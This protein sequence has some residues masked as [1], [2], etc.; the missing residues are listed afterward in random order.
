MVS[1]STINLHIGP[2]R[3]QAKDH[4]Q[5]IVR[6]LDSRPKVQVVPNV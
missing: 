5:I 2:L 3:T 6:A 4:D 1:V